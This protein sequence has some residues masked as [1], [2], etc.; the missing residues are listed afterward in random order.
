MNV[1]SDDLCTLL[2]NYFYNEVNP[3]LRSLPS[4]WPLLKHKLIDI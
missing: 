3:P 1:T 2:N 4:H